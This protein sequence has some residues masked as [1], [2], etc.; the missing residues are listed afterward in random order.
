MTKWMNLKNAAAMTLILA[1]AGT[2]TNAYAQTSFEDVKTE[3]QALVEVTGDYA[4]AKRDELVAKSRASLK[5]IDA[6]ILDLEARIRNNW[7]SMD[8]AAKAK[9]KAEMAALRQLRIKVAEDLAGL[10]YSTAD[11]WTD[12]K[13]GFSDSFDVLRNSWVKA[14]SEFDPS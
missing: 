11:A 13:G 7:A 3:A 4:Y 8:D 10:R 6:S 2:M 14:K 12:M 5:N 9:A 1:T